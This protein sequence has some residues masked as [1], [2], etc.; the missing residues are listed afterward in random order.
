MI[1]V[2]WMG[3]CLVLETADSTLGHIMIPSPVSLITIRML[4]LSTLRKSLKLH[5]SQHSTNRNMKPFPFLLLFKPGREAVSHLMYN[6][7]V[8]YY[9]YACV[10]ALVDGVNLGEQ[11]L[12][13]EAD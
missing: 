1:P 6:T 13:N 2:K 9:T 4:M 8:A 12:K 11:G 10:T 5:G 7:Q 3:I